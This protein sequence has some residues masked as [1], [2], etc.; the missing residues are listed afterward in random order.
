MTE[1][2][3]ETQALTK[4]FGEQVAVNH[5]DM[6]I[7]RGRIY[8]LLGRNGAGKTTTMR[9]LLNLVKP[10]TGNIF[11]FGK[12][13]HTDIG[14]TYRRIGSLVE[15]PGF[16][17][18]LTGPENLNILARLRGMHRIDCVNYALSVVGLE[19]DQKKLFSNYSMGMKQRLAIAA[20]IMHE[21]ELLI[22]DEPIN[23]LDP[24]GI[25]ELRCFLLSLCKEKGITLLLSSH[26]LSEVEQ[27]ADIIGVM[28]EGRLLEE[29]E[30]NELHQRNRQYV[31]FE[32]SNV[33]TAAL[34][35]ERQFHTSDYSV[36]DDTTIRLFEDIDQRG[37]I[38]RC[39]VENQLL[40]KKVHVSEEKLEDYF[41]GVIGGNGNV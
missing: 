8:C 11:L 35:L 24:I 16:Y 21:P 19:N 18:N 15:A 7:P 39:F 31:E 29:V 17:E 36:L 1:F 40:V 25:H 14:N 20:A 3:I 32:V 9:M 13:H 22:L 10:S 30:M 38:N 33:N 4:Q 6:H 12:P 34:L 27:L 2:V 23:G 37:E 5:I 41:S 26:V 28:H